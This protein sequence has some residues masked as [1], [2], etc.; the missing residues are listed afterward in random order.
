MNDLHT[1]IM[2]HD[3]KRQEVYST[4]F[5]IYTPVLGPRDL[6][7][8]LPIISI[9]SMGMGFGKGSGAATNDYYQQIRKGNTIH[10]Y[11]VG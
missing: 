11:L 1:C 5:T 9:K 10:T 3:P 2:R 4:F 6:S 7:L 8:F